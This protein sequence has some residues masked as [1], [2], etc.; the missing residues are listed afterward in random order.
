MTLEIL[1][2][3]FENLKLTLNHSIV[4]NKLL[5]GL[6]VDCHKPCGS[7]GRP[8]LTAGSLLPPNLCPR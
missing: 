6:I 4:N 2:Y 5:F 3:H 1:N 7:I 8:V